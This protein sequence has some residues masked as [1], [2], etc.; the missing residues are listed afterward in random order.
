MKR[1][2]NLLGGLLKSPPYRCNGDQEVD[3]NAF[4]RLILKVSYPDDRGMVGQNAA[5]Y[6]GLMPTVWS[7][8]FVEY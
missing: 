1:P 7:W 3:G 6:Y 2:V 5:D 8:G 4:Q